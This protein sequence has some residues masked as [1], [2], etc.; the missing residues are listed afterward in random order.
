MR[1]R[2]RLADLCQ[3]LEIDEADREQ[4]TQILLAWPH[5]KK[6]TLAGGHVLVSGEN[7]MW[8]VNFLPVNRAGGIPS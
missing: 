4:I 7:F 8:A 2:Y 3:W 1:G 5:G 6:G